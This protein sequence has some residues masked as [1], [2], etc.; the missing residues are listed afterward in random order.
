V[1]DWKLYDSIYTERYMDSPAENPKG[2]EFGSVLTHAEKYKGYLLI[3]HGTMDDNVHMQNTIQ[4]IDK[5]ED[6]NK[7]FELMLYP[8]SRHGVGYPKRNHATRED[9][10]FWFRHFL[11]EEL[12]TTD[13]EK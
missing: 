10:Q 6:L 2:Y 13:I 12:T 1:T 5:L 4:L 11:D 9:V 8:N 7:D 3:T